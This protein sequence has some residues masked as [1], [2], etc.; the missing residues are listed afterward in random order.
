MP[1]F[2]SSVERQTCNDHGD[3]DSAVCKRPPPASSVVIGSGPRFV[4]I[5]MGF[6]LSNN[7]VDD[8][9]QETFWL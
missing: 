2:D 4:V 3:Q 9:V 6:I 1:Y 5:N 8:V 7:S